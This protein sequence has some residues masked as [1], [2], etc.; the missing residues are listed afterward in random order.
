[1]Q[2]YVNNKLYKNKYLISLYDE[3]DFIVGS[4]KSCREVAEFLNKSVDSTM[5]SIGRCFDGKIVS[6]VENTKTRKKYTVFFT[7]VSNDEYCYS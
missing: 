5:C 3:D 1:M 6:I 4:F 2:N 7:D